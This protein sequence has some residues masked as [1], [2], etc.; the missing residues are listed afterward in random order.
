MYTCG[1]NVY[2]RVCL[3]LALHYLVRSAQEICR[4]GPRNFHFSYTAAM[5][6]LYNKCG[7]KLFQVCLD[8][9]RSSFIF[10]FFP[11]SGYYEETH[12]GGASTFPTKSHQ[13]FLSGLIPQLKSSQ[14]EGTLVS[15][16]YSFWSFSWPHKV[17]FLPWCSQIMGVCL[18]VCVWSCRWDTCVHNLLFC[19]FAIAITVKHSKAM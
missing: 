9:H 18:F 6:T 12:E 17:R 10:F 15:R 7:V 5:L 11:P 3:Q 2:G 8:K 13:P 1:S 14:N 16:I 4:D 19:H